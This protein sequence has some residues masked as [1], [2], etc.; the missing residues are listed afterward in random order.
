MPAISTPTTGSDRRMI[1][2]RRI[3]GGAAVIT[4]LSNRRGR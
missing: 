4:R 3:E 2:G 1:E